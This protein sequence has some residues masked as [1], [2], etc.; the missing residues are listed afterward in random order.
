MGVNPALVAR[1]GKEPDTVLAAE[2]GV[3]KQA[4]FQLRAHRGIPRF[5]GSRE[6]VEILLDA[7]IGPHAADNVATSAQC[8]AETVRKVLRSR[9]E[10][11]AYRH[12]VAVADARVRDVLEQH[13]EWSDA[14]IARELGLASPTSVRRRRER[15]DLRSPRPPRRLSRALHASVTER[16]SKQMQ[17]D[18]W[19]CERGCPPGTSRRRTQEPPTPYD[20]N[21]GWCDVWARTARTMANRGKVVDLEGHTVL[22]LGGRYYDAEVPDGV[23]NWRELP[24]M[25]A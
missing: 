25:R 22:L 24:C 20:I 15:W 16:V 4:V 1:L 6:R 5:P 3:S 23:E 12:A 14:R 2:F 11:T 10:A 8:S 21:H 7:V 18:G 17:A 13:P 19:W 9:Q